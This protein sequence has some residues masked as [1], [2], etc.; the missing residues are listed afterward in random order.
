MAALVPSFLFQA[1]SNM[2]A[3]QQNKTDD[4]ELPSHLN[5]DDIFTNIAPMQ[6]NYRMS[7]QNAYN[8]AIANQQIPI[9]MN[10]VEAIGSH[11]VPVTPPQSVDNFGPSDLE[12]KPLSE[13]RSLAPARISPPVPT[14]NFLLSYPAPMI[15]FSQINP[16]KRSC[17]A[18]EIP[19]GSGPQFNRRYVV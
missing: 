7:L 12:P 2:G 17:G 16:N 15:Q 13:M 14:N 3:N 18:L 11:F 6:M 10:S 4:L 1:Q 19:E 8:S 9:T 5:L